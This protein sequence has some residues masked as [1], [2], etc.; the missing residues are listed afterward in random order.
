MVFVRSSAGDVHILC[1]GGACTEMVA[2]CLQQTNSE[3]LSIGEIRSTGEG[4]AKLEVISVGTKADIDLN[5]TED[6]P[7]EKR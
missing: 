6:K 3:S 4:N 5:L 1:R 2:L 7:G